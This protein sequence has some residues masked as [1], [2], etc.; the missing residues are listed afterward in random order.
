MEDFF[1]SPFSHPKRRHFGVTNGR[2]I[3]NPC[4]AM[5]RKL[6]WDLKINKKSFIKFFLIRGV[7][8]VGYKVNQLLN[9]FNRLDN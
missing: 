9:K 5:P 3:F 6:L 7:F 4:N 8:L 2:N 1:S